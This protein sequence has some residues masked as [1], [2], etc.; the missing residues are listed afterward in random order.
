MFPMECDVGSYSEG[1][2]EETYGGQAF[3]GLNKAHGFFHLIKKNQ[4]DRDCYHQEQ[5]EW[6]EVRRAT[7]S[8]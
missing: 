6:K 2:E 8:G 4:R 3:P 1:S 7:S 5:E